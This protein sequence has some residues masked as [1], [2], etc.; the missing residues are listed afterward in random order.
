MEDQIFIQE[1][2]P[3]DTEIPSLS[4]PASYSSILSAVGISAL[5]RIWVHPLDTLRSCKMTGVPFLWSARSLYAGDAKKDEFF[6]RF[7]LTKTKS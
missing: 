3:E 2:L 4:L 1:I 5:S 7:H 6:I